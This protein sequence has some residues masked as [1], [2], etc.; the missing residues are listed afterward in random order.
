[1]HHKMFK[2]FFLPFL[3]T[4]LF[5]EINGQCDYQT[6]RFG[7]GLEKKILYGILPDYRGIPD[8]L[9]LDIYFP[10]GSPEVEKPLVIWAFGGGFFQ[11]KREDFAS[12][13]QEMA[14]KGIVSATIDYRLGFDGPNLGFGPP[15]SFDAAEILRAGYRGATDMKGAIRFLK[16]KHVEYGIDLDRIWVGG[17]SAGAVVALN[18]A[19]L[20]KDSEK[21]KECGPWTPVGVKP[22]PDLGPI[23]GVLNQNGY[24]AKVQGVF[25]FFGALLDTLA[26]DVEDEIAVF[27]YHQKDDPVVPC[28]ANPPYYP[29]PLIAQNYP[30]AYGSCV[31]TE[32]FK[33]LNL[34][35]LFYE[36]WIYPG[37]DHAIHNEQAV[38]D[39]MLTHAKPHLCKEIISNQ[40][41]PVT[42]FSIE[43]NPAYNHISLSG[44][45]GPT[46]YTIRNISGVQIM[47]GACIDKQ[48]ISISDLK[49]G[50]YLI[51]LQAG[52][53]RKS[54][55][56]LKY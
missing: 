15:F 20:N 34:D 43:P 54:L 51:E 47:K 38:F 21:P 25:N 5:I 8:S 45:N 10:V 29:I 40:N 1:M 48:A 13:C 9:F 6:N 16:A 46:H 2:S 36:T 39:F 23:E 42:S 56:W 26:V 24:D 32:R 17:A 41:V 33:H 7:F 19:F 50:V 44:L 37:A 18:A 22:R 14:K 53:L 3:F 4:C 27:S 52:H 12:V 55:K 28:Q 49:P 11:G 35:P 30:V 31:L